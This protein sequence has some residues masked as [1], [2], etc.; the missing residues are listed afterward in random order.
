ML[1]KLIGVLEDAETAPKSRGFYTAER[2]EFSVVEGS[3]HMASH[4]ASQAPRPSTS[5]GDDLPLPRAGA[6]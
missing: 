3:F 2:G 1:S 4:M 5:A 6:V